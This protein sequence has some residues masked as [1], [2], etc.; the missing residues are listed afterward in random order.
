M[1]E[2]ALNLLGSF[3]AEYLDEDI[4]K[5]F[6]EPSYFRH[7]QGSRSCVLMG[8]RGSGKTTALRCMS[9]EGQH[10]L[11]VFDL[12][13]PRS[14]GLYHRINTT[15]VTAFQGP[16]L[17][18][19]EWT[20]IFSHYVNLVICESIADYFSWFCAKNSLSILPPAISLKR[21][22]STMGGPSLTSA[23]DLQDFIFEKRSELESYINNFGPSKPQLSQLQAPVSAL[24]SEV[25]KLPG[26]EKSPIYV[27]LDEYENL[28]DYQQL[29][30]NTMIKHSGG[31]CFFKIGVRELGWRVRHTLNAAEQLISPADYELIHIEEKLSTGFSDFARKVCEARLERFAT[32]AGVSR[33]PLSELLPKLSVSEEA[34]LLGVA[35]KVSLAKRD[36]D[37]KAPGLVQSLGITDYELYVFFELA[38]HNLEDTIRDISAYASGDATC[39]NRYDNYAY[40]LLFQVAERGRKITKFYCGHN[41]FA[42]MSNRNIRFYLQLVY[43]AILKQQEA[44][45]PLSEPIDASNQ[46]LA[47]RD[48]GLTYLRELEGVTVKGAQ[49]TKLLLGF[50]RLFQ[51]MSENPLGGA[52]ERNQ[53]HIREPSEAERLSSPELFA[54]A[55]ELLREAVMH[56]ALVR[57]PGTKLAT[58]SDIRSYD[59]SPH[60][61]FAAY[62]N[63]SHRRKRKIAI[64]DHDLIAMTKTPQ[65]T[66]KKLLGKRSDLADKELPPQMSMFDGYFS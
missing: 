38:Q 4:F 65:T 11:G 24:L 62:F 25:S 36:L 66:I 9:Y 19:A 40:A 6:N 34:E 64:T 57:A 43:E 14:I 61:I 16:E 49:I 56:L 47:A 27:I 7:L 50:G 20:R 2:T 44:K 15:R 37:E 60:P 8:G 33:L 52:P 59:Y 39:A 22:G 42:L 46:T 51:I 32:E 21:F 48:V 23:Q 35:E 13:E 1:T 26:H 3:R 17:S 12:N 58:E 5:F 10:A 30:M 18:S 41:T 54:S 63:F 31:R 53:F 55:S 28:L 29:I 45:K